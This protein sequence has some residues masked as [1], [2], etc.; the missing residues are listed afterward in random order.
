LEKDNFQRIWSW[1]MES[2]KY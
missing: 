1:R 2:R